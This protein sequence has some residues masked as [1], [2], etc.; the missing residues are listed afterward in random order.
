MVRWTAHGVTRCA[1]GEQWGASAVIRVS[2]TFALL[3]TTLAI[4]LPAQATGTLIRTFV[5]ATGN[6]SNPCTITQPCASF[7]A[8]YAAAASMGIIAA[9]DPGK[10]GPLTITHPIT[11]DG[12][13]W[14]AITA[15]VGSALD[16]GGIVVNAGS[17]DGVI[18]RGLTIDGAGASG[19]GGTVTNGIFFQSGGSLTVDHCTI[20][21]MTGVGLYFNSSAT[22]AQ[23]LSVSDTTIDQTAQQGLSIISGNTGTI[24]ASIVHSVL[25][26]NANAVQVNAEVSGAIAAAVKDSVISNN[27]GAISSNAAAG[28]TANVTVTRTQIA[29]NNVGV[30]NASATSTIWLAQSTVVDNGIPYDASQ[31]PIKTYQDNYFAYNGASI[32]SL[33]NAA[34]Q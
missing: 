16:T 11:V 8:A 23:T 2:L 21:N 32:G 18:L 34:Q 27:Q 12:N 4:P 31:G 3:A 29:N 28:T 10:Y 20:R 7:A 25:I 19:G 6:D 30:S 17:G 26:N 22:T 13:G 5:S 14:A 1:V 24:T 15:P 9:L 33:T